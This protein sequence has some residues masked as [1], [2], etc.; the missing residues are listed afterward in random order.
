MDTETS[1]SIFNNN[2]QEDIIDYNNINNFNDDFDQAIQ[3]MTNSKEITS[4][5]LDNDNDLFGDQQVQ[6]PVEKGD[7]G[8]GNDIVDDN[9]L[10]GDQNDQEQIDKDD[11]NI[12]IDNDLFGEQKEPELVKKNE[13]VIGGDID[14]DIDNDNDNDLFGDQKEEVADAKNIDNDPFNAQQE[15]KELKKDIANVAS[16]EQQEQEK[17]ETKET[18]IVNASVN[19]QQEKEEEE[20]KE[21]NTN[22]SANDKQEEPIP[23][24]EEKD[25]VDDLFNDQPEESVVEKDVKDTVNNEEQPSEEIF[26]AE[27]IQTS[28][29]LN[30]EATNVEEKETESSTKTEQ[31]VIST[32]N[33]V[34]KEIEEPNIVKQPP[35]LF[36]QLHTVI[37]PAY[38]H[39]FDLN[40]IT[41]REIKELPEFFINDSKDKSKT[42]IYYKTVRNF[43]VNTYRINPNEKMT[44]LSIRRNLVGDVGSLLRIFKFLEKWGIINYQVKY[45]QNEEIQNLQEL[46][47]D[48]NN[49]QTK[50]SKVVSS[51]I[52]KNSIPEDTNHFKISSDAPKGLYPFKS[53]KPSINVQDLDYLKNI[54]KNKNSESS[55]SISNEVKKL[56]KRKV[57]TTEED[58]NENLNKKQK[59][60]EKEDKWTNE[61]YSKL[62]ELFYYF[63]KG[64]TAQISQPQWLKIAQ[65]LNNLPNNKVIKTATDCILKFLQVPIDD[66]FL[67]ENDK[68]GIFK[69]APYLNGL[70]IEGAM[71]NTNN[72]ANPLL[73]TLTTLIGYVDM[74][75][76][77]EV[78][79]ILREKKKE[80]N[81]KQ[82]EN[83][84]STIQETSNFEKLVNMGFISLAIRADKMALNE[85]CDFILEMSTLIENNI[86]KIDLKMKKN[87]ILVKLKLKEIE[88]LEEQKLAFKLDKVR[89]NNGIESLKAKY[90]ID[91]KNDELFKE[92]SDLINKNYEYEKKPNNSES[93]NT[94][95]NQYGNNDVTDQKVENDVD[96]DELPL[97][98][99]NPSKYSYWTG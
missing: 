79:H 43:I 78:L 33:S 27:P 88:K 90:N 41:E 40:K 99:K 15:E 97:S 92:F 85:Y 69:Y 37:I 72:I 61:E 58:N 86:K 1:D 32:G 21:D 83:N 4:N 34:K 6:D 67:L 81:M 49:D 22:P 48:F 42:P 75:K 50:I 24:K 16:T 89:I 59:K 30:N 64:G 68:T 7:N 66:D 65:E 10:F 53:Y 14:I 47:E 9:D 46:E 36:P 87:S 44:F 20:V 80:E 94:Q 63:S 55:S 71:E 95:T 76:L 13:N 74:K 12:D 26:F 62:I 23:E 56:L 93:E 18:D 84:G 3:P 17:V 57:D 54:I 98:I 2:N 60:Q 11:N 38:S 25:I 52:G 77:Q 8:I 5:K 70:G 96:E 82:E 51:I 29:T 19:D 39:W 45:S 73:E 31:N 35:K 28:N 91:N